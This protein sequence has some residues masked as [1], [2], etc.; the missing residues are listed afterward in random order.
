MEDSPTP[1]TSSTSP[2]T[3]SSEPDDRVR[4][5]RI[6]DLRQAALQSGMTPE[7][8]DASFPK[9]KQKSPLSPAS[10]APPI[11]PALQHRPPEID[12]KPTGEFPILNF[13]DLPAKPLSRWEKIM[14][15]L[16]LK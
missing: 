10:E 7:E 8:V 16:R 1:E 12:T 6:D 14:K 11:Q 4:T 9:P 15:A 5:F 2:P 3:K 13:Q